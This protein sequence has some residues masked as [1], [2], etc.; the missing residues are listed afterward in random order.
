MVLDNVTRAIILQVATHDSFMFVV[1]DR[2]LK[3]MYSLFLMVVGL[4]SMTSLINQ[5][6]PFVFSLFNQNILTSHF[7]FYT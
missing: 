5:I 3:S 1:N 2:I 6:S 7:V 4:D